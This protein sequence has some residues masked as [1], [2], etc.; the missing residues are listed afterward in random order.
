MVKEKVAHEVKSS[1]SQI[2]SS[3]R[4]L[5]LP[6]CKER[7]ILRTVVT[8]ISY[9]GIVYHIGYR[10]WIVGVYLIYITSFPIP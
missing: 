5:H 3:S 10:S 8:F 9:L 4:P 6:F 2:G 7:Y 1:W